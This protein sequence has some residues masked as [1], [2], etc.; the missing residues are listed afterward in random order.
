MMTMQM[1]NTACDN[2]ATAQ[3]MKPPATKLSVGEL[4]IILGSSDTLLL[5]MANTNAEATADSTPNTP[6][7]PARR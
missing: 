6:A 5:I 4:I 1:M 3:T 2:S 7:N